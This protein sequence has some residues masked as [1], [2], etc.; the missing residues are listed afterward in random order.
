ME[1]A[2]SNPGGTI[3]SKSQR[4]KSPLFSFSSGGFG[5]QGDLGRWV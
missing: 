5:G 3:I 1:L 2:G 4:T